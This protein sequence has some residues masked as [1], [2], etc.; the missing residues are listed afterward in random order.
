MG[1][2][3]ARPLAWGGVAVLGY[4]LVVL[5]SHRAGLTPLLPLFDGLAPT[6]P[7]RWVAPPPEFRATNERP[8]TSGAGLALTPTGSD[9]LSITTGDGQAAIII[10]IN[11]V[12]P[13]AG[14]TEVKVTITPLDPGAVVPKN[15]QRFV[16]GNAYRLEAAYGRSGAPA[17]FK[18]PVT[19]LLRY[20]THATDMWR[21]GEPEWTKLAATVFPT[22]LQLYAETSTLGTFILTGLDQQPSFWQRLLQQPAGTWVG[23]VVGVVV[24]V[25]YALIFLLD[26]RRRG[27]PPASV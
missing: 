24:L 7:Y 1:G 16:N 9:P 11:V 17:V 18:K 8:S 2:L 3:R 13:R 25:G 22:T 26:R 5:V 20:P 14:E 21:S 4:L 6:T 27:H 15:L 10:A 23:A 19:I 12:E